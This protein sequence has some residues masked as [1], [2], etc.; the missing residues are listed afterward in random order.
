MTGPLLLRG[1]LGLAVPVYVLLRLRAARRQ[2]FPEQD[3]NAGHL[4]AMAL[5]LLADL[6]GFVLAVAHILNRS[7]P[8]W[9]SGL[10]LPLWLRWL[11]AAVLLASLFLL[12]WANRQL[13]EGGEPEGSAGA[14]PLPESGPYRWIRHPVYLSILSAYIGAGVMS[15]DLALAFVPALLHLGARARDVVRE[16]DLLRNYHG[17]QQVNQLQRT[18]M[19]F[20]P[21][22]RMAELGSEADGGSDRSNRGGGQPES[23][24]ESN[25][26]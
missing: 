26:S 12:A 18:G 20:P 10:S 2:P 15:S 16:E 21:W 4:T 19:F 9:G 11:G 14:S 23:A 6:I 5:S 25:Q 3:L 13:P 17:H 24:D 8:A 1:L 7:L 22:H